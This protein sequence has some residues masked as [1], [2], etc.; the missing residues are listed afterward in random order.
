MEEKG[1]NAGK[2]VKKLRKEAFGLAEERWWDSDRDRGS[3]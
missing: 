2:T 3:G 1:V